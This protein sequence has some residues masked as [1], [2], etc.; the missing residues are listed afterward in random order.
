MI[1]RLS[2]RTSR[3]S[4]SHGC[5]HEG[6]MILLHAFIKKTQKTPAGDLELAVKRKKEIA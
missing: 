2:A 1:A 4:S 5:E 3:M 6:R